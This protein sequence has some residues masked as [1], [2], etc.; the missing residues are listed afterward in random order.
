MECSVHSSRASIGTCVRCGRFVCLSCAH[1]T[2][3]LECQ[4][5]VA[6]HAPR[7]SRRLA[8]VIAAL[9]VLYAMCTVAVVPLTAAAD[10]TK[11]DLKMLTSPQMLALI[12]VEMIYALDWFALIIAFL[13]WY[14]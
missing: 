8:R 5:I 4:K 11:P 10:F 6:Q 7:P 9:L 13:A 12:A 2:P 3:C 14:V 1:A